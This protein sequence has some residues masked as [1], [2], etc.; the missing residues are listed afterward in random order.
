MSS[1]NKQIDIESERREFFRIEDFLSL[2]YHE[3]AATDLP[4]RLEQM[5][6]EQNHNFTIMS[7]LAAISQQM[8][9]VMHTIQADMPEIA[10]YL[11]SLDQKVDLLGRA[12]LSG[13][14]TLTA[15]QAHP[16]NL[17]ASGIAF[18]STEQL[19]IGAILELRLLLF[20]SLTG[21]QTFGEVVGCNKLEPAE[22]EFPYFIRVTFTHMRES[23]RDVLVRH[24]V[25]RQTALLQKRREEQDVEG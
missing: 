9:G 25:Q 23:D 7:G 24:I 10:H 1:H 4:Q 22:V 8:T 19:E 17:S 15:E 20:P 2:S 13:E 12:L 14:I 11:K 6:L 18:K 16:V 5:E 3:V 21:L